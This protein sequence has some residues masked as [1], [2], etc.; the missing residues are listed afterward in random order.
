[1][2]PREIRDRF[3]AHREIQGGGWLHLKK[4][5]ITDDTEMSLAL[6]ASILD[7]GAVEARAAAEAFSAWM[8]TKPADIGHTVRRGLVHFRRTGETAVPHNEYNAGNG[9]CMRT[10][11]V[12]LFTYGQDEA[13]VR[14]AVV[15]QA[16]VTHNS[17]LA[18]AGT[19]CTV[20]MI[21]LALSGA[22]KAE[23]K[24]LADE[25][26]AARP[27]YRYAGK[28]RENPSGFIAETLQVVFQA[29]FENDGFESGLIETVNR[30]GDA[31]TTGAIYGMLGGTLYGV[32]AIPERWLKDLDH[33][34]KAACEA[35][36]LALMALAQ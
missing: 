6:G 2:T 18:D 12:A 13:A 26:A 27:E 32:Q 29:L 31:D 16:H 34:T 30:G 1:M 15:A 36:A 19:L 4:G 24:R 9:A 8:R 17:E 20:R 21:Q 11:P 35:Q 28:P 23:L 25:L 5:Q 3:G 33:K 10:L 22:P 7:E 14:A